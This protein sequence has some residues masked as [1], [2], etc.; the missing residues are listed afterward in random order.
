MIYHCQNGI[1]SPVKKNK[2]IY[3]VHI[4]LSVYVHVY[5]QEIKHIMNM[6]T[7]TWEFHI[8]GFPPS[9]AG[10]PKKSQEYNSYHGGNW[11]FLTPQKQS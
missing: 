2:V 1:G 9:T 10:S 7:W 5:I 8:E 11:T 3:N 6:Y 4:R